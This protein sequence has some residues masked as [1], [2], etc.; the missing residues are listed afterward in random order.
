M[1]RWFDEWARRNRPDARYGDHDLALTWHWVQV[2]HAHLDPSPAWRGKN[3]TAKDRARH[4]T[5]EASLDD[6]QATRAGLRPLQTS[7][8]ACSRRQSVAASTVMDMSA[9]F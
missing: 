6:K 2:A 7:L 9:G 5:F 3:P 8:S 4:R 1:T